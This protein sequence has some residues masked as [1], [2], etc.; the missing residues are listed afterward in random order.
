MPLWTR[1]QYVTGWKR[2]TDQKTKP[3]TYISTLGSCRFSVSLCMDAIEEW[4]DQCYGLSS[5]KNTRIITMD[6]FA[7]QLAEIVLFVCDSGVLG[8]SLHKPTASYNGK[9]KYSIK[10]ALFYSLLWMAW[11]VVKI[12]EIAAR[13]YVPTL[14]SG[15]RMFESEFPVFPARGS[16]GYRG[17]LCNCHAQS[18]EYLSH[19][20]Q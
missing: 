16:H 3:N 14:P 4:R 1:V 6:V 15:G 11:G 18:A 2:T 19:P 10:W 17:P 5:Q 20:R 8:Y 9:N 13:G 7:Y 12:W